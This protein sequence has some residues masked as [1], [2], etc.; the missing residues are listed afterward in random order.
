[1]KVLTLL[2]VEILFCD[3][4]KKNLVWQHIRTIHYGSYSYGRSRQKGRTCRTHAMTDFMSNVNTKSA[5]ATPALLDIT[6]VF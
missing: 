2:S 4:S 3:H 5:S 6:V 1:M